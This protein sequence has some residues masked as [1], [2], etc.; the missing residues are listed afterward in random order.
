[1][2]GLVLNIKKVKNGS[3]AFK[4]RKRGLYAFQ[5]IF[6]NRII[7]NG[8]VIKTNT[9]NETDLEISFTQDFLTKLI[10]FI[11]LLSGLGLCLIAIILDI[12]SNSY[13]L[14]AG[15]ILLMIGI[16]LWFDINRRFEKNIQKYK[17]LISEI[18]VL[19]YISSN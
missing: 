9:K 11:F 17:K 1:M 14:I 7:V 12:N 13:V 15:G 18:L 4:L 3:L 5:V 19:P 16:A 10:I 6:Q 2:T 8:K